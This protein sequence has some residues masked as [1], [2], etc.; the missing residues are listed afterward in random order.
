MLICLSI[1]MWLL[2]QYNP[3]AGQHKTGLIHAAQAKTEMPP[4][5][6]HS[7]TAEAR[8]TLTKAATANSH[9]Q[10]SKL[11]NTKNHPAT[12][13][14]QQQTRLISLRFAQPQ[15]SLETEQVSNLK[16]ALEQLPIARNDQIKITAGAI[17]SEHRINNEQLLR[18]RT[19]AIARVVFTY[20][21]N[22][23]IV[24]GETL[25]EVGLVTLEIA[26]PNP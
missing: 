25:P 16:H 2:V 17:S 6:L 22:V 5:A 11:A 9:V 13:D 15:A 24:L 21:Q 14:H 8:Q 26:K 10:I 7:P 23:E 20:T 3:Q 19:Q 1:S 12:L 18:L 4:H